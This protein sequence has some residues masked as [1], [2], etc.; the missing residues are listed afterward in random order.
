MQISLLFEIQKLLI[1]FVPFNQ[2][3]VDR[4]EMSQELLPP[5]E[6]QAEQMMAAGGI[7][8]IGQLCQKLKILVMED[9]EFF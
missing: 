8:P 6:I 4:S 1:Y 5:E 2:I 7:F 3:L 9:I